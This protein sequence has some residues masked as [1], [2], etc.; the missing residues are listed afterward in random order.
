MIKLIKLFTHTDLDG[1]GCAIIAKLVFWNNVDIEYCSYNTINDKIKKSLSKEKDNTDYIFVTDI[2]V[3][4]EVAKA[5]EERGNVLLLDHHSTALPLNSYSWCNVNLTNE[6]GKK[7][8]GTEM[9]YSWL[10]EN[11]SLGNEL[12]KKESLKKFVE[13]VRLFDTWEWNEIGEE[14][15]ICK[16]VNDLLYVYGRKKF[17]SW[18]IAQI[19]DDVFPKLYAD[20][21]LVLDI[22]QTEKENYIESKNQ[23]LQKVNLCGK[24]CGL[25]FAENYISELGNE[26]AERH[27]ELDFI[28]IVNLGSRKIC[29]RTNKENVDVAEI[30]KHFGGGGHPKASGSL[31]GDNIP[32]KI[33]DLIFAITQ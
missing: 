2:S 32:S 12:E 22:R 4:D 11:G 23:Q 29:F 9:F 28:A 3:N 26:L 21:L 33:I 15:K 7:T 19:N 24:R 18:C 25:I 30:A 14:G 20:D 5:L 8:S 10:K 1:L 27:K 17:I 13:L 31:L 16:Q 6:D